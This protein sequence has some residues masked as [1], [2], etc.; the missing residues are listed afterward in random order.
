MSHQNNPSFEI[1]SGNWLTVDG[2]TLRANALEE[3]ADSETYRTVS[4]DELHEILT[5]GRGAILHAIDALYVKTRQKN[6][7]GSVLK[8]SIFV[9]HLSQPTQAIDTFTQEGLA[10]RTNVFN[11]P[12]E[13]QPRFRP[14]W[15]AVKQSGFTAEARRMGQSEG[16]WLLARKPD[17]THVLRQLNFKESEAMCDIRQ[18]LIDLPT[19]EHI[20]HLAAYQRVGEE[21]IDR[22]DNND[23]Q[24]RAR[25][26]ILLMLAVTK[27]K[28]VSGHDPSLVKEELLDALD[29]AANMG[30]DD[31]TDLI[32]EVLKR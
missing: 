22:T 1:R 16:S 24:K 19:S 7:I 20:P 3:T 10:N 31:I 23:P 15:E 2:K 27:I 4:V 30:F 18:T 25:D 26:Q 21:E 13:L 29:Y 14:F 9:A 6:P 32:E 12:T 17:T 28:D 5:L 8:P 11:D